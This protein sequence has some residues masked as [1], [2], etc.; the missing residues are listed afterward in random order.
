MKAPADPPAGLIP[1]PLKGA[2]LLLTAA[3]Y[4]AGLKRGKTWRRRQALVARTA[5]DK[6]LDTGRQIRLSCGPGHGQECPP[7]RR[8]T[9]SLWPRLR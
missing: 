2:V 3:E 8:Q 1:A 5:H 4:L 6:T 9:G 7:K